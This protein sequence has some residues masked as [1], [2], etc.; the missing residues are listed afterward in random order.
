MRKKGEKSIKSMIKDSLHIRFS[1]SV[2]LEDWET[3]TFKIA[4][5]VIY[6]KNVPFS[7]LHRTKLNNGLS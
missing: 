5:S 7:G 2:L 3:G 6:V 4:E 1:V